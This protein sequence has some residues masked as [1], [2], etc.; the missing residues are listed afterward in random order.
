VA[1]HGHGPERGPGD[2]PGPGVRGRPV[3]G[4]VDLCAAAGRTGSAAG[5]ARGAAHSIDDTL[6]C[7]ERQ[8]GQLMTTAV[9]L[10]AGFSKCAELPTQAEFFDLLLAPELSQTPLQKCITGVIQQFLAEVFG[11]RP[12]AP[13]PSLEDYFTCI[14]LSANTGHHLGIKYT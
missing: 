2:C 14:D 7:E 1:N 5:I 3:R 12:S 10:G 11:W 6:H 8:N 13:L 9:I 4:P